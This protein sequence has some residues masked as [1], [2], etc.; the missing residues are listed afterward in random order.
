MAESNEVCQ[1][2][3]R[4]PNINLMMNMCAAMQAQILKN[5]CDEI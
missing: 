3:V 5:N 1:T 4:R 2:Q